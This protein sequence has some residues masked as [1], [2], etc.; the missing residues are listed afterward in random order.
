MGATWSDARRRCELLTRQKKQMA[1]LEEVKL[2]ETCVGCYLDHRLDFLLS[3]YGR[4]EYPW[5]MLTH[6]WTF[7]SYFRNND[8]NNNEYQQKQCYHCQKGPLQNHVSG[9]VLDI[10]CNRKNKL[11]F[12]E[13]HTSIS[14]FGVLPLFT[15]L[16]KGL[17]APSN[18][19]C[20]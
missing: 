19:S 5:D 2:M 3:P 4:R 8:R 15:L 18:F 20:E 12:L 16:S 14:L 10:L 9:L 6:R 1:V 7:L 17:V 11:I 13:F